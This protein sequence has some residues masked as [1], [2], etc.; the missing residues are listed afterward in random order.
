MLALRSVSVTYLSR[1]THHSGSPFKEGYSYP[2][3]SIPSLKPVLNSLVLG[4]KS[5]LS[6]KTQVNAFYILPDSLR[7]TSN[8]CTWATSFWFLTE[9][10]PQ[11]LPRFLSKNPGRPSLKAQ[12]WRIHLPIQETQ[13]QSLIWEHPTC[14]GT[15][16]PM[17]HN[18]RACAL[19]PGSRNYWNHEPQL[20]KPL[21]LE[22]M[23]GSK[24][25]CCSV[26]PAHC[27]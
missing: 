20:L 5:F 7:T 3:L 21:H 16:K 27:N 12:W 22:P 26:K 13:V 18:C 24:R 10:S 14:C 2:A 9:L 23:L 8:V 1:S 6:S 11:A 19:E 17:H 15:S 4:L 25:S